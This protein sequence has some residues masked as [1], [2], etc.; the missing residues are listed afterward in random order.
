MTELHASE[1]TLIEPDTIPAFGYEL[2][3]E[4]VLPS[5]LGKE[6]SSILYWAGKDLARK[7]PLQNLDEVIDFFAK[8]GWG[9][10]TIKDESKNEIQAELSSSVISERLSKK[11]STTTFQLEAG[12]LAQQIENQRNV[13]AECYEH[14]KKRARKIDFTVKWDKKDPVE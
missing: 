3:R 12:F 5:I 14:P 10:L 8:A 6:T 11:D 13:V 7:F 2:L 4:V 9:S 1:M